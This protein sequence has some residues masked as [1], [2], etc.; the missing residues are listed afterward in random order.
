MIAKFLA[1]FLKDNIHGPQVT[2][3][4]FETFEELKQLLLLATILRT[5][6]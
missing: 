4:T 3:D 6:I 5:P 2:M 1:R